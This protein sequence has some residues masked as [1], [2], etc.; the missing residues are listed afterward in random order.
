MAAPRRSEAL[1]RVLGQLGEFKA[2]SDGYQA[3]CPG[4]AHKRGDKRPSLSVGVGGDGRVLLYCH[5]GCSVE[6]IC[7]AIGITTADLFD[8]GPHGGAIRRFPMIGADGSRRAI[9]VREDTA[10]GKLLHWEQANGKRGLNGTPLADLPL[11]RLPDLLASEPGSTVYVTEGETAADAL[12]EHGLLAVGTATGA[13]VI[14]SAENLAPLRG[15]RVILWADN[16]D[17]GAAHMDAIAACLGQGSRLVWPDAPAKGDAADYFKAG[18]LAEG[19][20]GLVEAGAKGEAE[21]TVNNRGAFRLSDHLD[22]VPL[23]SIEPEE[24]Q[25]LWEGRIPLGKLT[26]LMGDPGLGKSLL[27]TTIASTISTGGVFKDGQPVTSSTVIILTA[28]DGLADTVRPRLD[29]ARADVSRIFALRS[30]KEKADDLIGRL[31]QLANDII[32][33]EQA[34]LYTGAKLVIMDPLSAYL[35]GVDSHKAAEV[36]AVLA[37]LSAMAERTGVAVLVVHH[38]NKGASANALYRAGGSLDFVAAARSVLGVVP[39]P[40]DPER[41][42]L[43]SVKVN[44]ALRPAGLGYRVKSVSALANSPPIIAWDDEPVTVDPTTAF[45]GNETGEER[46]FRTELK[47]FLAEVLRDGPVPAEVVKVAIRDRLGGASETTIRKARMELKVR[48][49]RIGFG[50]AGQWTWELSE[51]VDE[52]KEPKNLSHIGN[53][54]NG[55]YGINEGPIDAIDA[56][57]AIDVIET[58]RARVCLDCGIET[59]NQHMMRCKPCRERWRK[60]A[61]ESEELKF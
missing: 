17:Q 10:T 59:E 38:L 37:P 29:A 61:G 31:F 8:R 32:L 58:P 33:L 20:A 18:G 48:V 27:T 36:R 53:G 16:D 51:G 15:H 28:E 14:P 5:G 49:R 39:D 34:I 19:L 25:W 2:A 3:H 54:I 42:L 57:D 4:P 40:N 46:G 6:D 12:S 41:R 55:S 47:E 44:I 7:T 43:V 1:F 13:A 56:I 26:V 60:P 45:S 21:I 11:Y 9:H 35:G 50:P 52:P 24:V 30:V 23:S 22:L